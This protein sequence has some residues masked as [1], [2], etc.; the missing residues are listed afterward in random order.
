M[1]PIEEGTVTHRPTPP[2]GGPSARQ[3][4]LRLVELPIRFLAI[5]AH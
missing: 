3:G 1:T 5:A 4:P 2:E